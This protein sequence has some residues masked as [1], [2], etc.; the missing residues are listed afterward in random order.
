MDGNQLCGISHDGCGDYTEEG[1]KELCEMLE[2]TTITR[3]R[4]A[5]LPPALCRPFVSQETCLPKSPHSIQH[6]QLDANIEAELAEVINGNVPLD[7]E[8][9]LDESSSVSEER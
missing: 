5:A 6:N 3:L 7:D 9:S 1:I 4:C 8:D 2:G